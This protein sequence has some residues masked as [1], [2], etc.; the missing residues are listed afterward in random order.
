MCAETPQTLVRKLANSITENASSTSVYRMLRF[1]LKLTLYTIS[2]MQH[3]KPSGIHY[4]IH[5]GR[6]MIEN[7]IIEHGW[8]SDE[9]HFY[10]NGD[11]K[12]GYAFF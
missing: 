3:L 11:V 10:L 1:D 12:N 6:W 9:T 5:F 4:R 8:F 2:N 7:D